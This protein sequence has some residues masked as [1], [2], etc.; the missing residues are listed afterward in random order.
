MPRTVL[1]LV[2]ILMAIQRP[3]QGAAETVNYSYG[4]ITNDC[5]PT[6]GLVTTLFLTS[7]PINCTQ[8]ELPRPY[9]SVMMDMRLVFPKI[10]TLPAQ[11][12]YRDAYRCR[13][14]CEPAVSGTIVIDRAAKGAVAGHYDLKFKNGDTA[15]GSFEAK[16]CWQKLLCG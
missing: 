16:S 12:R 15:A 5:G 8:K 6:D 2:L 13:G 7:Q 4:K 3:P 11:D 1:G 14:E 9:I 10:I